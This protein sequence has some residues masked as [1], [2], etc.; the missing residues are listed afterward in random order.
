[1]AGNLMA[2][3]TAAYNTNLVQKRFP[4]SLMSHSLTYLCIMKHLLC[5]HLYQLFMKHIYSQDNVMHLAEE[6]AVDF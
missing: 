2:K 5:S 6:M 4:L 1:M 3:V